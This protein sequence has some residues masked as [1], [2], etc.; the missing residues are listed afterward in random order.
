VVLAKQRQSPSA[1]IET[2]VAQ[3]AE[4]IGAVI[5]LRHEYALRAVD[6]LAR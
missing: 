3:D 1:I 5:D 6:E 4:K 2:L